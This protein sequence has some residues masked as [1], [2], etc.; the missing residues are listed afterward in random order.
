[1]NRKDSVFLKKLFFFIV[2]GL[3]FGMA[4]EEGNAQF[5]VVTTYETNEPPF[6][7]GQLMA[8]A[9]WAAPNPNN[10][11][12]LICD[13]SRDF[14]EIHNPI[15]NSFIAQFSGSA[16]GGGGFNS[17]RDLDIAYSVQ[18]NTGT[19]DVV[20]VVEEHS[21]RVSMFSLPDT[22][23]LGVFGVSDLNQPRG[24]SLYWN[25]GQLQAFVA[26]TGTQIDEIIVYNISAGG[27]GLTGTLAYRFPTVG[28]IDNFVIDPFA[29][30]LLISNEDTT[31]N[32]MVYDL[33]G[34]FVQFFGGGH[35]VSIPEGI[36]FFDAGVGG[37]FIVV[38]E[39][40]NPT[41]FEVFDR[42]TYSRIGNF[43][44]PTSLTN[45]IVISQAS[46][47]PT[48]AN[49][50]LYAT[51]DGRRIQAYDWD[52]ISATM[53]F[54]QPPQLNPI[55]PQM[56]NENT[57]RGVAI[58]ATDPD[59]ADLLTLSVEGANFASIFDQGNGN[60]TINF[61]ATFEDSGEYV[62]KVLVQDNSLPLMS[63]TTSFILTVKNV[64]RL[65]VIT[66]IPTQA[67]SENFILPVA[68]SASDADGEALVLS[69]NNSPAFASIND[70]GNGTGTISLAPGF[71]DEGEHTVHV[72]AQDKDSSS[73]TS[74]QVT[75]SNTNRAPVFNVITNQVMEEGVPLNINVAAIDADGNNVSFNF[76]KLP[77][78]A[79][80]APTGNGTGTL[81][82]SPG[83]NDSNVYPNIQILATDDGTPQ[84]KD[85][86]AFDLTV[87]DFNQPP[88]VTQVQ[89]QTINEG[90]TLSIPVSATDSDGNIVAFNINN[91]PS[92][93]SFTPNGSTA[94]TIQLIPGFTDNGI[95]TIQISATDNEVPSKTT[96]VNFD[97][98]VNNFNPAPAIAAI[99]NQS[100]AEN[101]VL[102]VVI[103]AT[104]RNNNQ[105]IFSKGSNFPSFGSITDN[106]NGTGQITF[107]PGFGDE[108]L[109]QNIQLIALD[110]GAP[111]P[112]A[113]TASFNLAVGN[114]N[115]SPEL[116]DI[117][118][119]TMKEDEVLN[120][121]ITATDPD[122]DN[123]TLTA[124][125]NLPAFGNF[126]DNGNGTA[127]ITFTTGFQHQGIYPN[128]KIFSQDDGSPSLLDSTTFTLTVKD[129]NRVPILTAI[130]NQAMSEGDTL[131]VNL[132]GSDADGDTLTFTISNLPGF[133]KFQKTSELT[134]V[135]TFT[136]AFFNA[137]PYID[138]TVIVSDGVTAD[139]V[140]FDLTVNNVNRAP[141]ITQISAQTMAQGEILNINVSISDPDGNTYDLLAQGIPGFG[142]FVANSDSS[143]G[144]FSFAPTLADTGVYGNIKLKAFDHGTPPRTGISRFALT[145]TIGLPAIPANLSALAT[146]DT[147]ILLN[148]DNNATTASGYKVERRLHNG[149]FAEIATLGGNT[150]EDIGLLS[151]T[152]YT[153]RVRAF[154]SDGNSGYSN[155]ATESTPN[156]DGS[157][158]NINLSFN[159][160]ITASTSHPN[161]DPELAVDS[162][163]NSYWRSLGLDVN[164]ETQLLTVDLQSTEL[165]GRAR[166]GWFGNAFA[167]KFKIRASFDGINWD[168][169]NTVNN[170]TNDI[171]EFIFPQKWTRYVR[172]LILNKNGTANNY[173]VTTFELY[174]DEPPKPPLP[175]SQLE[176]FATSNQSMGLKWLDNSDDED[177]FIVL[178]RREGSSFRVAD[179]VAAD[180]QFYEDTD[181][182]PSTTY[183]YRL[184]ALKFVGGTSSATDDASGTTAE[185]NTEDPAISLT[186]N[187]P[188]EALTSHDLHPP[189]NAVDNDP[190]TL[191][192]SLNV[193]NHGTTQ[194]LK[195]DLGATKLMGRIRI[196][197][198]DNSY[199]TNFKIKTS[200]NGIDWLSAFN[201][202]QG[203][204]GTQDF[205]FSEQVWGRYVRIFFTTN[206]TDTYRVTALDLFSGA[207][208]TA[209]AIPT[210]LSAI[211]TDTVNI[212]LT[213]QDNANSEDGFIVERKTNGGSFV[214]ADTVGANSTTYKDSG[215]NAGIKY[216]YRIRAFNNFDTSIPSNQLVETTPK[217][218][219]ED[220]TIDL[221]A[222]KLIGASGS[223]DSYPPEL[224]IDNTANTFWRSRVL[225]ATGTIQSLTVNLQATQLLGRMRIGWEG[226]SYATQIKLKTSID[227]IDFSN[228]V[229]NTSNSGGGFQEF[230]FP[231][232]LARYFRII[233]TERNL[234]DNANNYKVASLE[235][236]SGPVSSGLEA[237]SQLSAVATSNSTMA[238]QW[239]DNAPNTDGFII[240]RTNSS[241]FS[242]FTKV[243]V[244]VVVID[245][246]TVDST[247]FEDSGLSSNTQYTY[248]VKAYN[249]SDTSD[250]SN[251]ATETT[252]QTG[253]ADPA[254]D[255]AVNKP[256]F[257]SKS[258]GSHPPELA[259]DNAVNTFWRSLGLDAT[260]VQQSLTV[261]LQSTQLVGR[262]RI[263]WEG[264]SYAEQFK[265]KVSFD[266]VDF[267]N[268]ILN[269]SNSGSGFREFTLPQTW[270]RYVRIIFT[271]KNVAD[272]INNYKVAAFEFYSGPIQQSNAPESPN[273]LSAV[274]T[275]DT[276][277][278]L[279]WADNALNETGFVIERKTGGGQ[280]TVIDTATADDTSY[281]DSGLSANTQY[282]YQIKA[283]NAS[284]T[285]DASNQATETTPQTGGAD[286]ATDLAVNK[287]IVASK[288]HGSHPPELAVDNA[289]N[290]FW[291]SL[292]LDATGVQQSLTVDLQSTQL[293][294]RL[295]IGW[296]GNSYADQFKLKAS[297]DG[298]DF[299]NTILNT[300]NSGGGFQDF[301]FTQTWAR[302]VRIIFTQ[303][304]VADNTNNYKMASFELYSGPVTTLI[305]QSD[306]DGNAAN[307]PDE[308][309]LQQNYP[310][311]FNPS[312][313]ISYS[314][315]EDMHVTIKIFN[316]AGQKI[317]TLV[318]DFR[319]RGQH[320]QTFNAN[321]LPSGTYFAVMKAGGVKQVQRL[322][323]MK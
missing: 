247:F 311:P 210:L 54:N 268:T 28:F 108:G 156:S 29:G 132:T 118:A 184:R 7:N 154:N 201:T 217:L 186:F 181:L 77:Q 255:L 127:D 109:F 94:G 209:P 134:G 19:Q 207:L 126:S 191:W 228:T 218:E 84:L 133:G 58:S 215:L 148:W 83:F 287:P 322:I 90:D 104:D 3:F 289:V 79:S 304:N 15:T 183:T 223:H 26:E 4:A 293:V 271:Q 166:I 212:C 303:R 51:D 242:L 57:I 144:T 34:N 262:L 46:L 290:T 235:L 138:I 190:T 206:N 135:L 49:G 103:S 80:F 161:H 299:S 320:R 129:S 237:P 143:Q 216:T 203:N 300:S 194:W 318:N 264:N 31:K 131:A 199:A 16:I 70:N 112:A 147:S 265:V 185:A 35:F 96:N 291:R 86:V 62:I 117:P 65:P 274:A 41:Q 177:G 306:D 85:T 281:E 17:P 140:S 198:T 136:P 280:F 313:T 302:Y 116:A 13:N 219:G 69:L 101:S 314:V 53:G 102:N 95:Y 52:D 279:Q 152:T 64:N 243:A 88:N 125:S 178:R 179:T 73:T 71:E 63:D 141:Q 158:P 173:Q 162:D 97:L 200:F 208:P 261:D 72:V 100:T 282:T 256:I 74:F 1:M 275:S 259:V 165:I 32:V 226:K 137:G 122:G 10:S 195:I 189:E 21:S 163:A 170:S 22:S 250:V 142:S 249:A 285:S 230:E 312:T 202:T 305:K 267:S 297:S 204:S 238:L 260:G 286:P 167:T 33:N 25:N 278:A 43:T 78:F 273:Q 266:G 24:I 42:Q 269:T 253:G 197:W 38:A 67:L 301:T 239:T 168:P 146:S 310:N 61:A 114:V 120:F 276:A 76:I 81:T 224:A 160:P 187:K 119:K 164:D 8:P 272:N 258:H 182:E 251:E 87:N 229:L 139:T 151:D 75:I 174:S 92:F 37:G 99:A 159:R 111:Q 128:I 270:A 211:A 294:G 231:Q 196:S 307:I 107:T 55:A 248:R 295:R 23:F 155:E 257:A 121:Q 252:P 48:F 263:G 220:P 130:P 36:S 150:Y 246:M 106:G 14:L 115:R 27:Q 188:I 9:L 315:P 222:N 123:I 176:V 192:R 11:L 193:N 319:S 20:F 225:A 171:R 47:A 321:N 214:V 68:V 227:G 39:K 40:S 236:Y 50:V 82:F 149:S 233:F 172:L 277:I 5:N 292:G 323:L 157:D 153:Y 56:M 309:T 145:V 283:Y 91:L 232:T 169:V 12:L 205:V 124:G 113:D 316:M 66:V 93:G 213:W 245:T 6:G 110:N 59:A 105:I 30:R 254:T 44:G 296:E 175:A 234:V 89:D 298:I 98:T 241:S 288:S 317:K 240:E 221:A 284:D 45:G 180:L 2:L 60:G 308:V 244:N 18:T